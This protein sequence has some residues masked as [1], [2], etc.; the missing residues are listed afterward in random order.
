MI[1]SLEINNIIDFVAREYQP[2]RIILFGSFASGTANEH[3]DL[4]FCI[5]KKTDKPQ[6]QRNLEVRKLFKSH[7]IPMDIFVFTPEEF[8]EKKNW[9]NHIAFFANKYGK[10]EYENLH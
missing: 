5:I 9:V 8:E 2:E 3:S 7:P 1:T 6:L 10:I 4:D